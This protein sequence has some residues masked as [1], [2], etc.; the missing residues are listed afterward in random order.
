VSHAVELYRSPWV[1][2]TRAAAYFRP[3]IRE[4][5]TFQW[6]KAEPRW[7]WLNQIFALVFLR[8]RKKAAELGANSVVGLEIDLDPWAVDETGHRC[9]RITVV[10]TAA[11][12]EPLFS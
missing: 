12:L 9:F 11:Q 7:F 2:G 1:S 8:L 10:G 5:L 3:P 6:P 4:E